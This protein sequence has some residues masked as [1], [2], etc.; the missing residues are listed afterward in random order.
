MGRGGFEMRDKP[1]R[2]RVWGSY[3]RRTGGATS[4]EPPFVTQHPLAR[5]PKALR[6]VSRS[7]E[8][9]SFDP[10]TPASPMNGATSFEETCGPGRVELSVNATFSPYEY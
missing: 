5:L 4:H 1:D 2:K 10:P 3:Y 9:V 6:E 8:K 7:F